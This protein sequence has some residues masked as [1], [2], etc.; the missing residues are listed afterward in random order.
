MMTA[1]VIWWLHL[2][3][4]SFWVV[5]IFANMDFAFCFHLTMYNPRCF[6][7]NELIACFTLAVI[8]LFFPPI[9]WFIGSKG[10]LSWGAGVLFCFYF[11]MLWSPLKNACCQVQPLMEIRVKKKNESFDYG[12]VPR[13]HAGFSLQRSDKSRWLNACRRHYASEPQTWTAPT[14]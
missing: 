2:H 14:M 4:N 9:Y 10:R 6:C 5:C 11:L 8:E 3:F 1:V 7:E 12:P 13:W